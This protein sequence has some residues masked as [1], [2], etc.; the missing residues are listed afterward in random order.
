MSNILLGVS[1]GIAAYKS[2]DLASA[3]TQQ[4]D[5]VKTILTPHA[6]KFITPL[7]FRAVTQQEVLCDTFEDDPAYR[8]EHIS[9]SDWADVLVIAP[10][11][12]DIIARIAHGF[13]DNLLAATV[14]AFRKPVVV[15]PA[16]NDRM[17]ASAVVQE[18]IARLRERVG[19]R[20][21]GPDEGHLA[22]GSIGPGRLA[23][24]TEI[25]REIRAVLA[26]GSRAA[27][28]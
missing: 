5:V 1:A 12:A 19:C 2:A 9:L 17:W 22:C 14:L 6:L 16:M 20:I 27:K 24:T 15:A 8:P 18:N 3:L 7:T 25:I 11:T 23:E 13:G 4:G 10:A 28:R 21:V 26:D